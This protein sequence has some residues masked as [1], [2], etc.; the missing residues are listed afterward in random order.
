[1]VMKPTDYYVLSVNLNSAFLGESLPGAMSTIESI[2]KA[3]YPKQVF[4]YQ[5]FDDNI[6]AFYEQEAKYAQLFQMF[7]ILFLS[8]G[9]LGLY[10]LITFVVNRKSKEMAIRKVMGANVSQILLLFSKEYVQMISLS[11]ALAIPVAYYGVTQWLEN[12]QEKIPLQ[13]WLF[14]LPGAMVLA[15]ALIVITARS[16]K[17]AKTNPIDSLRYE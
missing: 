11:L 17:T 6:R 7:S 5:F 14:V 13:W 3:A 8:I 12:F 10:G 16:M 1:M 4:S 9:C 15:I 2:W